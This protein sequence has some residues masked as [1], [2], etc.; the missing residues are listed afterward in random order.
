M[1]VHDADFLC[2]VLAAAYLKYRR[3]RLSCLPFVWHFF[4]HCDT[5]SARMCVR[6]GGNLSGVAARGVCVVS[7]GGGG[8]GPGACPPPPPPREKILIFICKTM[9]FFNIKCFNLLW[10]MTL[11]TRKTLPG[12]KL[13]KK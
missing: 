4:F 1:W 13:M 6:G 10:K 12:E 11:Q 9:G 3:C 7:A 2:V 8:G 5:H